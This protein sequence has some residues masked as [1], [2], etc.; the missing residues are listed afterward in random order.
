MPFIVFPMIFQP[1]IKIHMDLAS[2]KICT[3]LFQNSYA[4]RTD[5]NVSYS[6]R[7]E[8]LFGGS[9]GSELG[10]PFDKANFIRVF[11]DNW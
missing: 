6:T 5:L 8:I 10:Q 9:Q 7:E 1:E 2:I 4:K 11:P 3:N